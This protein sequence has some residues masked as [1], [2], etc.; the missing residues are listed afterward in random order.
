MRKD[1]TNNK[2]KMCGYWIDGIYRKRVNSQKHRLRVMDAYGIDKAIVEELK[3]L[4]THSVR[5]Q[6]EDTGKILDVSFDFFCQMGIER[7][8]DGVQV[9]LPVR[10]FNVS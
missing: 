3:L 6:E 7:D 1:F 8:L 10:Y 5:I 9:F 2:G 4:K